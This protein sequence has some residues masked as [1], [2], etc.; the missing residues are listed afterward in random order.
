MLLMEQLGERR[1]R[2]TIQFFGTDIGDKA[3]EHA[4]A[5]VYPESSM[6]DVSPERQRRFFNK[7]EGGFQIAKS[8]RDLCVFARHDLAKDPPFSRLDLI[9]CRNVLIYLGPVL[10]KRVVEIFHYALKPDGHLLL[11]KSESL[12]GYSNLFSMEDSK[13]K[14]LLPQAVYS[15]SARRRGSSEAR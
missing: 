10:Q 4:R 6:P 12:S 15:S 8:L 7:I 9:S 11:G 14:I 13:H 3:I 2:A 5:G 1:N